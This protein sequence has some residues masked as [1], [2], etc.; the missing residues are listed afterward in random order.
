MGIFAI[1]G[2]LMAFLKSSNHV[3]GQDNLR[4]RRDELTRKLAELNGS[5]RR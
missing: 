1:V 2:A 3:E 4:R 5:L